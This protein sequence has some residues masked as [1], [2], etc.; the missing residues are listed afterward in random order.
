M[1]QYL[2]PCT[3]GEKVRVE[4]AQAGGQIACQCGKLLTVPTLRGLRALAE[5]PPDQSTVVR[6]NVRKWSKL[7]GAMF[8][9]G[10][11]VAV[12]SLG[13]VAYTFVEYWQATPYTRDMTP[14]INE[15]EG[16]AI[17]QLSAIE[18]YDLFVQMRDEGLGEA[19]TPPWV[20]VQKLVAEQRALMIGSGIAAAIGIL[21][22]VAALVMRPAG[23]AV[24]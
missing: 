16:Q 5:A 2:L 8:S 17:E 6:G 7:Q 9:I 10:L 3:C 19:G 20:Q 14:E 22:V 21:S 11:L 12:V 15:F 18:A 4:P 1:P 24:R 23:S 13:I